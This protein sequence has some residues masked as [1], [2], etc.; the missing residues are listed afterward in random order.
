M[1]L[2][3]LS[4]HFEGLDHLTGLLHGLHLQHANV[5]VLLFAPLMHGRLEPIL[6]PDADHLARFLYLLLLLVGLS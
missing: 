5:L 6:V 2:D 1:L 3:V 4:F